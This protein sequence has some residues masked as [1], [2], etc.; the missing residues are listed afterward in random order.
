MNV[1]QWMPYLKAIF[2]ARGDKIGL[3]ILFLLFLALFPEKHCFTEIRKTK[4]QGREELRIPGSI[5]NNN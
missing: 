1:L 2:R 4:I 5:L 3:Q